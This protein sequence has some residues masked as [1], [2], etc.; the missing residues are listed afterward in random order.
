MQNFTL[1]EENLLNLWGILSDLPEKWHG[2]FMLEGNLD[3]DRDLPDKVE[4]DG[5][6]YSAHYRTV[7]TD[8]AMIPIAELIGDT[9]LPYDDCTT[10]VW[11]R[12][13]VYHSDSDQPCTLAEVDQ[14]YLDGTA[15][16]LYC[17][18]IVKPDLN[19]HGFTYLGI[20]LAAT[21]RLLVPI[22]LECTDEI[23]ESEEISE[24][25]NYHLVCDPE[26]DE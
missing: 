7:Y 18:E 11:E 16:C 21:Y 24:C 10:T 6:E 1:V 23:E 5:K 17:T 26:I 4:I 14:D 19:S 20:C 22:C 13:E 12:I 2:T 25:K 15:T 9:G 3:G 8:N